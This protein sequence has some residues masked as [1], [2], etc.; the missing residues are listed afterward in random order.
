LN[1]GVNDRRAQGL[2]CSMLSMTDIPP[3]EHP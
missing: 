2:L 3:G 1:S